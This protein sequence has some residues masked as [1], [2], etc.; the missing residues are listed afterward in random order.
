MTENSANSV[1]IQL[2]TDEAVHLV[3]MLM[4]QARE[5]SEWRDALPLLRQAFEMVRAH[6]PELSDLASSRNADAV[7]IARQ[8]F[9]SEAITQILGAMEGIRPLP[10]Q[11]RSLYRAIVAISRGRHLEV[12]IRSRGL[13][14]V[15]SHLDFR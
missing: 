13:A 8:G 4:A 7:G 1:S 12:S 15:D 3:C 11:R 9:E 5:E 6:L 10:E 14:A 2:T